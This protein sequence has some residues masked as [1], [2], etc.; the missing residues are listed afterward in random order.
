MQLSLVPPP[1]GYAVR[2]ISIF[3]GCISSVDAALK[4]TLPSRAVY[5]QCVEDVRRELPQHT[6]VLWNRLKQDEDIPASFEAWECSSSGCS[7]ADQTNRAMHVTL[8]KMVHK[9]NEE[10]SRTSPVAIVVDYIL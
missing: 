5:G 3:E 9:S 1:A 4:N 10:A 2:G 6:A 8:E 7:P